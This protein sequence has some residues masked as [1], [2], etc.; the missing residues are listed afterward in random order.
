[1]PGWT[2]AILLRGIELLK[3][4]HV[5]RVVKDHGHVDALAGEAGACAAGQNGSAGG[6]ASR[7]RGFHVGGVARKNYADGQLAV[8]R[9][10]GGVE[11]ARAEIEADE[12]DGGI[13]A[14]QRFFQ[15]ASSSR[16]AEKRS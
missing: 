6:A 11:S 14:A 7:Q 1:M 15:K 10:I 12:I 13:W 8:I 2:R 5:A 4:I 16:C 9:R 3:C